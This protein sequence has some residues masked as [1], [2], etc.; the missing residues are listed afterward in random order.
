MT[1]AVATTCMIPRKK[2]TS[3][4]CTRARART[5]SRSAH[6]MRTGRIVNITAQ[7]ARGFPG[8]VHTGAARAGVEVPPQPPPAH[9][10]HSIALLTRSASPEHDDD[11]VH[12]VE[13]LQH[14]RAFV[15][16]RVSVSGEGGRGLTSPISRS[17]HGR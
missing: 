15:Q 1:H 4:P 3:L 6:G 7:V 11:A 12:R 8:M 10:V 17:L 13:P 16:T 5:A 9:S 2:G 14:Q